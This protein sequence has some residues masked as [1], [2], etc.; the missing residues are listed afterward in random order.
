M[1]RQTYRPLSI[2]KNLLP[3]TDDQ[4]AADRIDAMRPQQYK[5]YEDRPRRMAKWQLLRIFKSATH[6]PRAF[7]HGGQMIADDQD[8]NGQMRWHIPETDE[9]V[10]PSA[11]KTNKE[12]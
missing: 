7:D 12:S 4:K 5:T 10:P 3:I 9:T 1:G 11:G 6:N 8:N 2:M